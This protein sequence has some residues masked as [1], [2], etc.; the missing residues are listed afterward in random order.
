M[1]T[2][3]VPN[4]WLHRDGRRFDS[5]PYTSGALEAKVRL[6]EIQAPKD[7][8]ADLTSGYNGGIFNGPQFSRNWVDSTDHGV[9]FLGSSSMLLAD[10]S[11][12]P[13]LRKRDA[14]SA[15]LAY[16]RI[17]P[18][19]T[20]ISCS[21]TIGRMV[22]TRPDMDGMWTSQHIMK[23]VTDPSRVPPGY[24]NGSLSRKIR[25]ADGHLRHLRRDH[26]AHRTP[27]HRRPPSAALGQRGRAAGA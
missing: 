13:L 1:K 16:L 27:A 6:E 3:T 8:L 15:K 9:P 26:P 17:R 22:Y 4:S 18:G 5:G 2:K 14:E 25:R 20:L 24:I 11:H 23:V 10:L 7:R 19:V 21:G 12:L